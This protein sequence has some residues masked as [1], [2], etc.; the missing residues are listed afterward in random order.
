MC[1]TQK[2]SKTIMHQKP[3]HS[4]FLVTQVNRVACY[5][6]WG[7][8]F[9]LRTK[10]A[11]TSA[12]PQPRL[13]VHRQLRTL[14]FFWNHHRQFHAMSQRFFFLLVITLNVTLVL[15]LRHIYI[16]KNWRSKPKLNNN[17]IKSKL[18]L[19]SKP[20][21]IPKQFCNNSSKPKPNN[22]N[23]FNNSTTNRQNNKT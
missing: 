16:K 6:P 13:I 20:T 15:I 21:P 10:I 19:S 4:F 8:F 18:K 22:S 7:T 11:C 2:K 23:N 1:T 17:A 9:W 12:P 5:S 14:L 3:L